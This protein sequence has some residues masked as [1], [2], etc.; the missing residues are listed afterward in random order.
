MQRKRSAILI[1]AVDPGAHAGHVRGGGRRA[2]G[3][4]RGVPGRD[5]RRRQPGS[6]TA[7]RRSPPATSRSAPARRLPGVGG[8]GVHY[9]NPGFAADLSS[10]PAAPEIL[11]YAPTKDGWRLV[12]VEYFS[13]ALAVTDAGPAPWFGAAGRRRSASSTPR[14]RC[15]VGRST[16]RW[17]ATTRRCPGTT[18]CTS[19]SGRATRPA[20]SSPGTR[21]FAASGVGRALPTDQAVHPQ[22]WAACQASR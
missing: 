1:A 8:M 6:M 20:S 15:S 18:T 9:L 2:R 21:T 17:P 19:G 22:G 5:S 13:V 12:G 10:D 11:L 3:E 4:G 7:P 14:H 16:A